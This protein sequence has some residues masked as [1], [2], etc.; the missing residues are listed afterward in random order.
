MVSSNMALEPVSHIGR[1][2]FCSWLM[3]KLLRTVSAPSYAPSF[4]LFS[5]FISPILLYNIYFHFADH[6]L[7]PCWLMIPLCF[8]SWLRHKTPSLYYYYFSSHFVVPLT[9]PTLCLFPY[10]LLSLSHKSCPMTTDHSAWAWLTDSLSFSV[11]LFSLTHSAELSLFLVYLFFL[12]WL[13]SWPVSWLVL[14]C[15]SIYTPVSSFY[16]LLEYSVDCLY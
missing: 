12:I 9:R 2:G 11:L 7:S 6:L 13:V 8:Y 5:T 15:T 3:G 1:H 4:F 16:I 10:S 14:Y